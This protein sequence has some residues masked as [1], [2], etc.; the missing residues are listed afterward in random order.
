[1]MHHNVVGELIH[2]ASQS[3]RRMDGL[4]VHR[5]VVGELIH[6]AS[7]SRRKINFPADTASPF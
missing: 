4:V 5:N 2:G 7:Q 6:G 1:M 3:R